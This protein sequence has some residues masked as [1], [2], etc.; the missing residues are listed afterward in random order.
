[1]NN[2]AAIDQNGIVKNTYSTLATLEQI[3]SLTEYAVLPCEANINVGDYTKD[4]QY[5]IRIGDPPNSASYFDYVQEQWQTDLTVAWTTVRRERD[6]KLD[7]TDWLRLREID[8]GEPTPQAWL[9]YRQALR[10]ITN[11]PDPLNIVWPIKPS[12]E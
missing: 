3:Q 9:D 12:T 4:R 10:D 7:Q 5:F 8:T 2:F 6:R 11:Q 1:M